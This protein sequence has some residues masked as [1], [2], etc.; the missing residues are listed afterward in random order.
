M[1]N[2]N[3]TYSLLLCDQQKFLAVRNKIIKVEALNHE[4]AIGF[5]IDEYEEK[6]INQKIMTFCYE[7]AAKQGGYEFGMCEQA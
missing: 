5:F 7:D 4:T 3:K 2:I 6:I 1:S